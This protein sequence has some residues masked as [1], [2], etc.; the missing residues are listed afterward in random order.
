MTVKL[1]RCSYPNQTSFTWSMER[2]GPKQKSDTKK[3]Q[4]KALEGM[5]SNH[6]T[7]FQSEIS[8][9]SYKK[10]TNPGKRADASKK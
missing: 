7:L 4:K 2:K 10:T 1:A 9:Y 5:R 3:N 8:E 6:E